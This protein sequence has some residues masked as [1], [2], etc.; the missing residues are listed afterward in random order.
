MVRHELAS[1]EYN[2]RRADCEAGVA[3][4]RRSH[5]SIQALRDVT[6]DQ[7]AG[8]RVDLAPRV[9]ARCHHVIAENDRV[10]RAAT[11]TTRGDFREFGALMAASHASLRDDYEVSCAELDIMAEIVSLVDGVYGARIDRKSTRL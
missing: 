11:A 1:S 9:Y 3:V 10:E 8:A 2:L 4:L 5:P 6:L 7:L